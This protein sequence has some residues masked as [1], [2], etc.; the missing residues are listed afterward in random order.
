[1]NDKKIRLARLERAANA[2]QEKLIV[3]VSWSHEGRLEMEPGAK[4]IV[5]TWSD[6]DEVETS[7]P[8]YQWNGRNLRSAFSMWS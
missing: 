5:L 7:R 4:V 1:M 2:I 8:A 3:V 6:N